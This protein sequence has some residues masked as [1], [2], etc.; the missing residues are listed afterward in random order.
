MRF[1]YIPVEV[2]V[3]GDGSERRVVYRPIIKV[4]IKYNSIS[5]PTEALVDSGADGCVFSISF[6]EALKIDF[7]KIKPEIIRGIN[8]S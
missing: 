5:I 1:N 7:T 3:Y 6:G 4:E 2:D 8:S